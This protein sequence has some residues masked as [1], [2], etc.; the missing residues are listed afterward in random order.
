MAQATAT[1]W[2][3]PPDQTEE[4]L[5]WLTWMVRLRW[6]AVVAQTTTLAFSF[7]ILDSQEQVIPA[8]IGVMVCLVGANLYSLGVLRAKESVSD[9][10]LLVQLT[11]DVVALTTFFVLCGGPENVFTPLYLIHVAMGAIMLSRQRAALLTV[12]V[13]ACYCFLFFVHLPLHWENHSIGYDRLLAT[14]QVVSFLVTTASVSGFVVGLSRSLRRRKKQLLDAQDRTARTDR[15]RSVGTLAAGAAHELNTPLSTV[16]LRLRRVRRRHVD[17]DTVKDL[18]A[19]EGQLAR[20]ASIVEQLLVGAGDPTASDIERRPL[21][22][23]A[24]EAVKMWSRSTN[25]G[26]RVVDRSEGAVVEVPKIAF[27]QAMINLLEN[28]RQAQEEV[29]VFAPLEIRI[30]HDNSVAILEVTDHG[31]GLPEHADQVGEPFFTTKVTGTGLGVFVAR[32]LADGAGGGLSYIPA[33]VGTTARW[34]FPVV[35]VQGVS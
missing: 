12:L 10:Q 27:V 31:V 32:A 13:M 35:K 30:H 11:I 21:A 29:G 9:L 26:V 14:G 16:G 17:T 1:F 20:C 22:D 5:V 23:L 18:D 6:V 15:L 28:A 4:G 8:L 2:L 19:I 33:Q 3:A 25:L 24:G 7:V 34:W